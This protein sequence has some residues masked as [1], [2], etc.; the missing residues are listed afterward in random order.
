MLKPVCLLVFTQFSNHLHQCLVGS[1]HLSVSLG[2][3]RQGSCLP[4]ACELTQFADDVALKVGSSVTQ[5]LGWCSEDQDVSL[6]EK[7][8]NSFCHLIR[9]HIHHSVSFEV[10]TKD[11]NINYMWLLV[12]FHS[13]FNAS[14][15]HMKHLQR[16]GDQNS[17]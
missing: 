1:L 16:R 2:V 4:N 15:I 10:V 3:V 12:Q 7:F 8:S 13:H 5:E 17:L 9:S 11:Q 6:P 14:E